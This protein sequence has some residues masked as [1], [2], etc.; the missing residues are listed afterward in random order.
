MIFSTFEVSAYREDFSYLLLQP[1]IRELKEINGNQ[2]TLKVVLENLFRQMEMWRYNHWSFPWRGLV[3]DPGIPKEEAEEVYAIL[4]TVF[5]S[6]FPEEDSSSREKMVL[7]ME[8]LIRKVLEEV[9]DKKLKERTPQLLGFME[10]LL[11][12]FTCP[13]KKLKPAT[14]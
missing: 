8:A 10:K 5:R 14:A 2:N 13:A 4:D 6:M 9:L 7:Y 11:E 1:G 3:Y 12:A